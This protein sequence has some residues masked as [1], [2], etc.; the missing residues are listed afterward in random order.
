MAYDDDGSRLQMWQ[1]TRYVPTST[2][3]VVNKSGWNVEGTNW[4]GYVTDS[5][6]PARSVQVIFPELRDL[7]GIWLSTEATVSTCWVAVDTSV[8]TTNGID[9]VWVNQIADYT[10]TNWGGDIMAYRDNITTLSVNG[11][12]GIR[13]QTNYTANMDYG[14]MHLYGEIATGETP[15]RILFLDADASDAEFVKPLNFGLVPRGSTQD[16]TIKL[17]NNSSTLTANNVQITAEANFG[18]SGGWYTYSDDDVT[19]AATKQITS[20]AAT[21]TQTMYI[22]QTIPASAKLGGRSSRSKVSVGS[23]T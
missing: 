11:I 13:V 15:D 4:G 12:R 6:D 20:I 22:R 21:A 8:D 9:G 16:K 5:N 7:D 14:K 1:G 17:K 18:A 10:G 3:G 2:S 23:W 19:Y